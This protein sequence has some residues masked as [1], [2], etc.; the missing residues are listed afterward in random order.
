VGTYDYEADEYR[1][2]EEKEFKSLADRLARKPLLVGFNS[3]RFDTPILQKYIPF[4]VR[5]LPQLDIMEEI[6]KE[7][8]HRVGLDSIAKAT[9]GEGK[10]ASGLEAIR[11]WREGRLDELKR[12]C[13]NDVRITRDVY[14]YGASHREL[15]YLPKFGSGKARVEVS[16]Q[17]RHPEESAA[18]A[19]QHSLF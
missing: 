18:S 7:L 9:L 3:R 16:W 17:V 6:Q 13:I 4:D 8:G 10:T 15:F 14:E 11:L 12:Y 5:K 19:A 2:F 1:V